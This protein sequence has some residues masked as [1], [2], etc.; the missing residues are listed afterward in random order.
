MTN[1]TGIIG[2]AGKM[3][4][5]K[6]TLA[7]MLAEKLP[8]SFRMSFAGPLKREVSQRFN[9]PIGLC[10]SE[11]GK[12]QT[13]LHHDLPGGAM[14]VRRILQWWGTE[15][16]RAQDENYWIDQARKD[17]T[18]LPPRVRH[19]IIDDVRMRNEAEMILDRGGFLV[20]INTYPDWK[21][22]P[23]AWCRSETE[24]DTF[25]KWSLIVSPALGRLEDEAD[26]IIAHYTN[27]KGGENGNRRNGKTLS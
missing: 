24:L 19:L 8:G 16:R 11:Q 27:L 14:E 13:V 23:H 18:N 15:V 26:L 20:K 10:Y 1:T 6:S 9:I 5:G 3:G 21:P 2:I 12:N 4:S 25:G 17:I 22:G 7:G